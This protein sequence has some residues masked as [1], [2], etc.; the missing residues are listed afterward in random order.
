MRVRILT[1][2][3]I[4][5]E[6]CDP[7][8]IRAD[9]HGILRQTSDGYSLL[10]T[11]Q[12]EGGTVSCALSFS[13]KQATL[14]RTGALDSSLHFEV[15]CTHKS[16][17][18]VPPLALPHTVTT[19]ALSVEPRTDGFFIRIEYVSRIADVSQTALLTLSVIKEEV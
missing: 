12:T 17:Y 15:G 16:V 1:V 18:R 11:E 9:A 6:G 7:E 10:Y 8:K 19:R 4:C 3:Q 5:T 14:T 13:E 2:S